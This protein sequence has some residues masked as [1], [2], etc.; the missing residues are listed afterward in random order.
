MAE[1]DRVAIQVDDKLA[2]E[3]WQTYGLAMAFEILGGAT[4]KSALPG[5]A[6]ALALVEKELAEQR[7]RMAGAVY[8]AAARAGHDVA[9]VASIYT[10]IKD[11][12]P[13]VEV[14]PADLVT[15]AE[16]GA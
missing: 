6:L 1:N 4:P 5:F 12:R 7:A 3:I 8:R 15:R 2:G 14:E 10:N 13:V 9:N 16:G 11:G